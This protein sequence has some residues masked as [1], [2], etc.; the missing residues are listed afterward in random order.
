MG[1]FGLGASSSERFFSLLHVKLPVFEGPWDGC[2]VFRTCA[3]NKIILDR[4]GAG[5]LIDK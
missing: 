1:S 3:K 2:T 5:R 4:N